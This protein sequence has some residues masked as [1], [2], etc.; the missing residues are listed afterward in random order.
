MK[1]KQ[2]KGIACPGCDEFIPAV[3]I[4]A[5]ET[6]YQCGECEEIYEDKDEAKECCKE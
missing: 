5:E 4:P 1:V 2:I 3:D 6:R